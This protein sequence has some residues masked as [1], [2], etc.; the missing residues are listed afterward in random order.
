MLVTDK[1]FNE[2]GKR[3]LVQQERTLFQEKIVLHTINT[4]K[5][6][7]KIINNNNKKGK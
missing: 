1:A 4:I 5:Y 3:A 7:N 6:N 2:I